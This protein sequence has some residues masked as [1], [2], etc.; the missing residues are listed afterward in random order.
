MAH[1][2]RPAPHTDTGMSIPRLI[3]F[4]GFVC[5]IAALLLVTSDVFGVTLDTSDLAAALAS[6]AFTAF[7]LLKLVGTIL[8]MLGLVG[9]Y[10]RQAPAAGRLGLLGFLTAFAATG[11]VAGDWWFEAFV[12][13]WEVNLAPELATASASGTLLVGGSVSFAL[14]S[15]GW[16]LFGVATLRSRVFPRWSAAM[17]IVGGVLAIQ[18]GSPPFGLGLAV[19]V[20]ILGAISYRLGAVADDMDGTGSADHGRM[21][22]ESDDATTSQTVPPP[23]LP[24]PSV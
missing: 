18:V 12:L 4:A 7:T 23:S 3:R 24:A 20:G 10:L 17:L 16:T 2:L 8:L 11:L 22:V 15:L 13:P 14:F 1:N 6:P 9:L 19:A 5:V 21:P